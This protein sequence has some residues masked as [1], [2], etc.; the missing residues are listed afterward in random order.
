MWDIDSNEYVD[1]MMGFGVNLFG[2]NPPFIKEAITKRLE[3][4]IHIGPQSDLA[5]EVAELVCELTGMERV[6]IS[7]TGTEAV[8]TALRLARAATGRNKIVM[9]SGS[10]H[11]HF[12][13]TLAKSQI[14]DGVA[15]VLPTDIGVPQNIIADV[16]VL[17]EIGTSKPTDWV[18]DTMAHIINTRYNDEKLTIFTTNYVDERSTEGGETLEDRIGV[19]LRSRL[20]EMSKTVIIN[21]EDYRRTFDHVTPI[22]K[23]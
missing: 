12:D 21:G 18:R 7:N 11:G 23:R 15:T 6:T 10:Y 19:R 16:L 13:G 17:D 9:F 5:G 22:K 2:Y 14:I 1:L 20:F 8:M 3:Q 4:G